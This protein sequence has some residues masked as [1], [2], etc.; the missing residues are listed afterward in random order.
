[1][2]ELQEPQE[3]AQGNKPVPKSYIY[4]IRGEEQIKRARHIFPYIS[5]NPAISIM[6][7]HRFGKAMQ[8]ADTTN[9]EMVD[10]FTLAL[11]LP[12]AMFN[13]LTDNIT[14]AKFNELV[15]E[16]LIPQM[17]K[18]V[19][20][21]TIFM[22]EN[23]SV[24]LLAMPALFSVA[25]EGLKIAL[26]GLDLELTINEDAELHSK[27][28]DAKLHNVINNSKDANKLEQIIKILL[29]GDS[30]E[31]SDILNTPP[32]LTITIL[33][34]DPYEQEHWGG[35]EPRSY[36]RPVKPT[37]R[38]IQRALTKADI[39]Q[40]LHT[41]PARSTLIRAV[42]APDKWAKE[43]ESDT[44]A[45]THKMK[46][47]T[48]QVIVDP[49]EQH[50]IASINN[51]S[52]IRRGNAANSRAMIY[53]LDRLDAEKPTKTGEYQGVDIDP[54]VAAR[55]IGRL[56]NITPELTKEATRIILDAAILGAGVT[57]CK[58]LNT[59]GKNGG[60]ESVI[61]P[62]WTIDHIKKQD[63]EIEY[64]RVR[65]S[66]EF[67]GLVIKELQ[68]MIG[69]GELLNELPTGKPGGAWAEVIALKLMDFWRREANQPRSREVT[70]TRKE[71][72]TE[73]KP[74]T[75]DVEPLIKDRKHADRPAVYWADALKE[76]AR[77]GFIACDEDTEWKA[78]QD[79]KATGKVVPIRWLD[80]KVLIR[81]GHVMKDEIAC[82]KRLEQP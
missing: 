26:D 20:M 13:D 1:M 54:L 74:E 12:S 80:E 29:G 33:N 44:A 77:I 53:I 70:L 73:I 21:K 63:D 40:K 2:S 66:G 7:L 4:D 5:S 75:G 61:V 32:P 39:E 38:R 49:D 62:V 57:V 43:P 79:F 64:I 25:D 56:K 6:W 19:N 22:P 8:M 72:L 71:L 67:R 18:Y 46:K 11:Y 50:D 42:G 9:T 41:D 52:I 16:L 59:V 10:T 15:N 14:K 45:Y 65:M 31:H 76:L 35:C 58:K 37:R 47:N 60:V 36:I 69:K 82:V 78:A 81:P 55:A 34:H 30:L 27:E 28:A 68:P 23:Q 51:G 24:L 48:Y 17:A 3:Q